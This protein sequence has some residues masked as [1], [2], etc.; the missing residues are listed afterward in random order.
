MNGKFSKT[1]IWYF[2]L[3]RISAVVLGIFTLVLV[4]FFVSTSSTIG[5]GLTFETWH[6]FFY[7]TPIIILYVL[8]V[9][10]LAAHAWIGLWTVVT[11]YIRVAVFGS[12]TESF[13][14]LMLILLGLI[15]LLYVYLGLSVMWK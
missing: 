12:H 5:R 2:V 3:Q 1:G 7:S 15:L 4:G 6:S 9:L 14:K 8:S 13:R 11:D 10:S